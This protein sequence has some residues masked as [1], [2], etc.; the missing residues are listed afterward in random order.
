APPAG[1][2]PACQADRPALWVPGR[3]DGGRRRRQPQCR[4]VSRLSARGTVAAVVCE[5]PEQRAV[6]P[7]VLLQPP[8]GCPHD[9]HHHGHRNGG[10]PLRRPLR[11][12]KG[13]PPPPP[14]PTPP[15]SLDHT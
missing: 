8:P 1:A 10:G 15:P 14:R 11:P 7:V 4:P 2:R 12:P 3:A 5:V 9:H 13:R 6:R